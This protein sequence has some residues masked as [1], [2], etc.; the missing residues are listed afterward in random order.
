[1]PHNGNGRTNG[2][3]APRAEPTAQD[4]EIFERRLVGHS[5][6]AIAK[7]FRITVKEVDAALNRA[8]TPIDEDFRL[9]TIGL[10]LARFDQLLTVFYEKA[11][12][13]DAAAANILLKVSERRAAILGLDVPAAVR[14]DPVLLQIEQT[15]QP[16]ST[17]R[18]RAALDAI[19]AERKDPSKPDDPDDPD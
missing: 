6:H 2:T 4:L 13:G 9:T 19:I 7:E 15:P 11:I 1:M 8:C 3:T 5:V 16:T 12:N 14:K 18:I 10:E 17:D